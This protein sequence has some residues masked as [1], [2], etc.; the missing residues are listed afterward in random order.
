[1]EFFDWSRSGYTDQNIIA[2][3]PGRLHSGEVIYFVAHLDSASLSPGADDNASGVVDLLELARVLSSYSFSRTVVLLFTTGE[4]QGTF[5][6][7][8]YL[9]QLTPSEISAI[10]YAVDIDMVGYDANRDGIMELWHADHPPSLE[11]CQVIS[12]EIKAYDFDLTPG[13][14]VGCG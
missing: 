13:L 7:R 12:E 14:V 8:S 1:V 4:E 3:K 6:V 10:K 11:L 2:R 5:G 9:D